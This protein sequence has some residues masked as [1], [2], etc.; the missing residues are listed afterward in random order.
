MGEFDEIERKLSST[1]KP[2]S[3]SE[4]IES[5]PGEKWTTF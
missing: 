3:Y 5:M 4:N 1:E 2:N